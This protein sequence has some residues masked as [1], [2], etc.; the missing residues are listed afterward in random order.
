MH[1]RSGHPARAFGDPKPNTANTFQLDSKGLKAEE[2]KE[3]QTVPTPR[4]AHDSCS[5]WRP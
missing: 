1:S 5:S 2:E 3:L 4:L